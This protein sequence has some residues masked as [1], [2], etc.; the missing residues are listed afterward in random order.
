MPDERPR[1]RYGEYATPQE[2]AEI[3]AKSMPPVSPL[4][5]PKPVESA[6]SRGTAAPPHPARPV[7]PQPHHEPVRP[8]PNA[9]GAAS[10]PSTT[11][12]RPARRWDRFL[13]IALLGYGLFN[14]IASTTQY[15]DLAGYLG[16]VYSMFNL[17]EYQP[18]GDEARV[19]LTMNIVTLGLFLVTAIVTVMRLRARRIAFWVP[20]R[21]WCR[22]RDRHRH[23]ASAVRA[24]HRD[25]ARP[26]ELPRR[27][28][29]AHS[30]AARHLVSRSRAAGVKRGSATCRSV[31]RSRAGGWRRRRASPWRS[32]RSCPRSAGRRPSCCP[33]RRRP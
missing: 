12:G 26:A 32:R 27:V 23:S 14:V 18:S 29:P 7:A 19:G 20:H 5:T 21:G 16:R 8:Q 10:A 2:Q 31:R 9:P 30:A 17:G 25:P 1:P 4:L 13:S 28:G 15:A 22:R 6:D 33:P 24:R 11:R 3:V